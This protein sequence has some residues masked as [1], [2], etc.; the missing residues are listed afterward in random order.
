M[1]FRSTTTA[2]T[3]T[4]RGFTVI[5]DRNQK[6]LR[7]VFHAN[8]ADAA[9]PEIGPWLQ[10]VEERVGLGPFNPEPYWGFEDLRYAIGSRIRN[11]FYIIA[12]TKVEDSRE[13]FLYKELHILTGFSLER[14]LS[15]I[16]SGGLYIDFDARTGHNHGTKFR[17]RQ[18]KFQQSE[19]REYL[20]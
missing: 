9:D 4:K 13:Y 7:F 3:Y 1:S 16:E 2:T 14:F 5:V 17:L 10:W 15:C 20:P 19:L 6:K 8:E 11:S 12:D 18:R